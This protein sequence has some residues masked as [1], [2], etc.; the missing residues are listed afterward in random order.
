M[1]D[2]T[3]DKLRLFGLEHYTY[4]NQFFGDIT[5]R[6]MIGEVYRSKK[7]KIA[8][9]ILASSDFDS[10]HHHILKRKKSRD[11]WCS[12]DT[13]RIQDT[14][15]H[16][17]DTL[18]QSYTLLEFLNR[19][20]VEGLS[21]EAQ[22]ARQMEMITLYRK[23][24][25][26]KKLTKKFK[27]ELP[28]PYEHWKD[29]TQDENGVSFTQAQMPTTD[30]FLN[31]IEETL[32]KWES[33]GYRYYIREGKCDSK[34]KRGGRKSRKSK[35]FNKKRKTRRINRKIKLPYKNPPNIQSI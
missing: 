21:D 14:R 26:N 13:A 7:Y 32:N 10:G 12:V 6:K 1:T 9:P 19:P 25:S 8:E 34:R 4:I 22:E 2:C 27:E 18:C 30:V 3:E 33:F 16:K 20:I 5:V 28:F 17:N 31:K 24:L 11:I 15:V 35:I 23:I 29:F